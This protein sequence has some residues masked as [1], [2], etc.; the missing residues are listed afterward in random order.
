M[1]KITRQFK[2][3]QDIDHEEINIYSD[4]KGKDQS[5][6]AQFLDLLIGYGESEANAL[7][8]LDGKIEDIIKLLNGAREAIKNRC[9][10][11]TLTAAYMSGAADT[12]IKE[13]EEDKKVKEALRELKERIDI[14]IQFNN[15]YERKHLAA[16]GWEQLDELLKPAMKLILAL[17]AHQTKQK[18]PVSSIVEHT[19]EPE[20][21]E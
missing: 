16:F 12:R 21:E 19:S 18:T 10:N 17:E 7:I 2:W 6:E 9:D 11:D 20:G 5:F 15:L 1:T 14:T 3:N 13:R 4:G 8:A